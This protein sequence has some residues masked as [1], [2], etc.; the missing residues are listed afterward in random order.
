MSK[1]RSVTDYEREIAAIEDLI[2]RTRRDIG[3]EFNVVSRYSIAALEARRDALRRQLEEL[4]DEGLPGHEIDVVLTG[5][6]VAGSAI[7]ASFLSLVLHD[8]QSLVTAILASSN[9]VQARVGRVRSNLERASSL[10]FAGSFAGSFGMRL[11]TA[12]TQLELTGETGLAPTFDHFLSLLSVGTNSGRLLDELAPLGARARANYRKLLH[13]LDR[14]HANVRVVWP[15]TRGVREATVTS[16]TAH[17]LLGTLGR[18]TE[19]ADGRFFDGVLDGANTRKGNF[20]FVTDGGD[21]L[22]GA[23]EKEI[24]ESLRRFFDRRCR[25]YILTRKVTDTGTGD[26]RVHHRLQELKEVSDPDQEH[27]FDGE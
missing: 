26:S 24:I 3:A 17:D 14:E 7:D 10:R 1:L 11:E 12:D 20:E 16:T 19:E 6:P 9:G 13:H 23:V 15:T 4:G 27:L 25:A 8:V 22:S 2:E 5:T 18:V 21:V